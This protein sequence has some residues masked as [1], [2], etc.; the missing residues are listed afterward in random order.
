MKNFILTLFI[1]GLSIYGLENSVYAAYD[2]ST[3]M[4]SISVSSA[5]SQIQGNF[6]ALSGSS[7]TSTKLL[8]QGAGTGTGMALRIS[9][10]TPT[11][12][13]VVLDNGNVGVG[14][15]APL[16][17]VI[18]ASGNVGIANTNPTR[19]LDVV[20][21]AN[22]STNLGVGGTATFSG[23]VGIGTSSP[24]PI[25][26][27]DVIGTAN[28]TGNVGIGGTL[29]PTTLSYPAASVNTTA[30][31]TTT[32]E[33]SVTTSDYDLTLPGGAYGFYP[34]LKQAGSVSV[35]ARIVGDTGGAGVAIST[36]Y[37]TYIS[38]A[39]NG[40]TAY[41]QQTYVTAS[42]EDLWIFLLLDKIT[43]EIIAA[44]QAP[45]HP[46][47]GN[48]GDF[49][50]LPH[51][52]GSYD[53]AKHEIVILDKD[54]CAALKAESAQTGKSILTLVNEEYK[55]DLE[56]K[57][58]VPLHSGKFLNENQVQVKQMVETIPDYIKVRKLLSLTAE[59][60][61]Q[62]EVSNQQRIQEA[63]SVKEQEELIQGKIREQ[64]VNALQEE[65]KIK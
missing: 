54:T 58:Y 15:T 45:D 35:A 23:N 63:Q 57:P 22:I 44:Y 46:A 29:T 39:T 5:V 10:K 33:V 28:F 9:D 31:K 13:M 34:Q 62:K 16:N 20:G 2:D 65:G 17:K 61:E 32:G 52:F 42:G 14:T 1:L 11:D 27:L 48:G 38:I 40:A 26:Q 7:G 36:S 41:A 43:K 3:D 37:T 21:T 53:P 59:E 12:R 56:N 47:Y 64:A 25:R 18:I 24:S 4:Q 19:T 30:L 50:K 8:I 51:P 55:P 60:K 6:K 49:E